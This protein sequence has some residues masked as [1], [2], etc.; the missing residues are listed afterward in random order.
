MKNILGGLQWAVF[1]FA[2]SIAAPIAIA[3]VFGMDSADT[4]LFIQRTIFILGIACLVQVLIGHRLPINEGPAGIW[5][6]VF[7]VY[8]GMVG[9]LYP[10]MGQSLQVLQSGQMYS[11]IIFILL[12]I[13]G[14]IGK[15]KNLFTPT[16]TFVYLTLLVLQLSGTFVKG[17]LGVE[18]VGES[19]DPIIAVASLV[20]MIAT[21]FMMS[22]KNKWLQRYS[23]L[24][25][26]L[27]GW[28]LFLIVGKAENV[29]FKGDSWI[30]FPDVF[31]YGPPVWDT[32]MFVTALFITLLLV[33]NMM[34]SIRVMESVYKKSFG[35]DHPDRMK[36]GS[37]AS[38]VNQILAGIFS[39]IGPV[40]ISGAAGF[41]SATKMAKLKPFVFG[42]IIV[43]IIS[44]L[45]NVIAVFSALPAPVAF[46]VTFTIFTK[47]VEMAL[48]ELESEENKGRAYTVSAYA[49]MTGV[50]L[51]FVPV[52]SLGNLPDVVSVILSN[53]MIVGTIVGITLE[54]LFKK[55]KN[56]FI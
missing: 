3:H 51:M 11:G 19:V 23:V 47:M 37:I 43:V 52:D 4:S 50:G 22:S 44:V 13:T 9:I 56:Q 5:W 7:V 42:A 33:A 1:L 6:G 38:G 32:G 2:S 24:L 54:Q 36:H 28:L 16:I 21:Y 10:T 39:A 40:P 20:I 46:A 31:V 27:L 8:A 34:A 30:S 17:M 14:L 26:I 45:P 12:A 29:D 41:V 53:G 15:M 35:I 48:K 18:E 55:K 25:S 49:L